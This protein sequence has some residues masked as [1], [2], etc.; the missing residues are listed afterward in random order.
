MYCRIVPDCDVKFGIYV[1]E[2]LH[3]RY[4]NLEQPTRVA[5]HW[6]LVRL[7]GVK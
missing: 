3:I 5:E 6:F 4:F 2:A 1:F 7:S